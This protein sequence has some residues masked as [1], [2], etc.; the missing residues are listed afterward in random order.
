[1]IMVVLLCVA[2]QNNARVW[3]VLNRKY[4]TVDCLFT[5]ENLNYT[6]LIDMINSQMKRQKSFFSF[7]LF[8]E[9]V[10][11]WLLLC[12]QNFMKTGRSLPYLRKWRKIPR[13]I[14]RVTTWLTPIKKLSSLTMLIQLKAAPKRIKL[15]QRLIWKLLKKSFKWD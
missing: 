2:L 9:K 1:M 15:Q 5:R 7:Y 4:C 14:N 12:W 8:I 13:R 3:K 10:E 11:L 6:R